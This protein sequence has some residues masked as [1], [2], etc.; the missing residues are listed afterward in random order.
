MER[1]FEKLDWKINR[2]MW[3]L[4]ESQYSSWEE[5]MLNLNSYNILCGYLYDIDYLLL[6][7]HDR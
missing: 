5:R 1:Q 4:V 2:G 6:E 7:Y 3:D